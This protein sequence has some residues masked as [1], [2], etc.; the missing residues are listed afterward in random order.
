MQTSDVHTALPAVDGAKPLTHHPISVPEPP[1]HT[2]EL[3]GLESVSRLAR[4]PGFGALGTCHGGRH[5]FFSHLCVSGLETRP[6][7]SP[8]Y[9]AR[10]PI[11][12]S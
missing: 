2:N 9:A 4:W 7:E 3:T 5:A 1:W 12:V 6:R 10:S 11:K 8:L